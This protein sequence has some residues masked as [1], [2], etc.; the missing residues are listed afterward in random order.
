MKIKLYEYDEFPIEYDTKTG[1]KLCIGMCMQC[2]L[3]IAYNAPVVANWNC[4]NIIKQKVRRKL[5]GIVD[6]T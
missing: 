6:A 3:Y 1:E 4:D 5:E 2:P